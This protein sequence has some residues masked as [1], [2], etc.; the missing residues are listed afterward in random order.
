MVPGEAQKS[1]YLNG[2]AHLRMQ[3]RATGWE[4]WEESDQR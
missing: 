2:T 1:R 4:E 3:N